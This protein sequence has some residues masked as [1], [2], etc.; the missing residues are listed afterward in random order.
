MPTAHRP[1]RAW[2]STCSNSGTTSP[3][4]Q[5][6]KTA[7]GFLKPHCKRGASSRGKS[8]VQWMG[9]AGPERTEGGLSRL[10][11]PDQ[12]AIDEGLCDLDGIQSRALAK[13]V[14]HD[15][16]VQA[17]LDSRIFADAAHISGEIAHALDRRD[18]AAILGL[19]NHKKPRRLA[20][21][22]SRLFRRDR[23]FELDIHRLRMADEDRHAHACCREL[24][25]G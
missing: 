14:G 4:C 21:N 20:Q 8:I 13:I 24:D 25:L 2:R 17:M 10:P 1:W 15:P 19:I 3:S 22:V 9:R 16:E 6:V 23:P 12:S 5:A 11:F 7:L 18:V